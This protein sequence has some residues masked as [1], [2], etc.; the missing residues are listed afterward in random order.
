MR[1][2]REAPHNLYDRELITQKILDRDE[3]IAKSSNLDSRRVI[4]YNIDISWTADELTNFFTEFG[5]IERISVNKPPSDP[6]KPP[7]KKIEAKITFSSASS[8]NEIRKSKQIKS[9]G[10]LIKTIAEVR[11]SACKKAPSQE[12]M[13][14]IS[15]SSKLNNI[16]TRHILELGINELDGTK[17]EETVS[18][19]LS[20]LIK[21]R[22]KIKEVNASGNASRLKQI[23]SDKCRSFLRQDQA[24]LHISPQMLQKVYE[25]H[26][27]E[28]LCLRYDGRVRP[29]KSQGLWFAIPRHKLKK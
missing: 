28:G 7:I 25:N 8:V 19:S 1:I 13:A 23:E 26:S 3:R 5:K 9:V 18:P 4:V 16:E 2:L 27:Y 10:F 6:K 21:K 15:K 29:F 22:P 17:F 11:V 14:K 24:N 20:I 12:N